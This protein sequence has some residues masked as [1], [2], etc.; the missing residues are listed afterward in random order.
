MAELTLGQILDSA[1]GMPKTDPINFEQLR[2]LLNGML[3]NLGLRDLVVQES[4]EPPEGTPTI[5]PAASMAADLE[6]LKQKTEANEREIAEVRALCEQ[7][8]VEINEVKEQ[9]SH[10]EENMQKMQ[11]T[12][13]KANLEDMEENLHDQLTDPATDTVMDTVMSSMKDIMG[14]DGQVPPD[15]QQVP[16]DWEQGPGM[17]SHPWE[18]QGL[19]VI[20]SEIVL[21]DRFRASSPRQRDTRSPSPAP[22]KS[23]AEAQSSGKDL[24]P[25][26]TS[27]PR[28]SF[29]ASDMGWN[30]M[31]RNSMGP[32]K[33]EEIQMGI[34]KGAAL[35]GP[36]AWSRGKNLPHGAVSSPRVSFMESDMGWNDMGQI[37]DE[38]IKMGIS[39]GAA[40]RSS[41]AQSRG[42]NLL[43]GVTSSP[44]VSF[45]ESGVGWDEVD[46]SGDDEEI[47]TSISKAEALPSPL[48]TSPEMNDMEQ[49]KDEEMEMS[50]S[51]TKSLDG[52]V[53]ALR[54][55]PGSPGIHTPIQPM[56]AV[57]GHPTSQS[58]WIPDESVAGTD[59]GSRSRTAK[60]AQ[61]RG[62][63]R[64][65]PSGMKLLKVPSPEFL[66]R[67]QPFTMQFPGPP[68][69]PGSPALPGLSPPGSPA[70]S[71]RSDIIPYTPPPSPGLTGRLPPI[72]K[73]YQERGQREQAESYSRRSPMYCGG[74][75]T[76]I[77]PVQPME[78]LLPD[79]SKPGVFDLVGRDGIVYRGRQCRRT[80]MGSWTE[81]ATYSNL[82]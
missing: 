12:L 80:P 44:R 23:R 56:K 39:K 67:D 3:V 63:F 57:R 10:M 21:T 28:V 16:P 27:S 26:V 30:D 68:S 38:E 78:P 32:I 5:P 42:K 33:E 71:R 4:G 14:E 18:N 31:G 22:S 49:I 6:E 53:T 51:K 11:E 64:M 47:K 74:R 52:S 35:P 66:P 73:Q 15:W 2:N 62:S 41:R 79:P 24:P 25:G 61:G 45:V 77:C 7:L 19:I 70:R 46:E 82:Q 60:E 75:H 58:L 50:F 20:G 54:V 76:S 81:G 37:Q 8:R 59:S 29:M 55:H 36:K 72:V 43:H 13:N 40:H 69:P 48:G 34:P 9:Q 65:E 17:R 1:I